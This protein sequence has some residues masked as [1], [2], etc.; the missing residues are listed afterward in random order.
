MAIFKRKFFSKCLFIM[1]K[2]RFFINFI[3]KIGLFLRIY[4]SL[5]YSRKQLQCFVISLILACFINSNLYAGTFLQKKNKLENIAQSINDTKNKIQ[6]NHAKKEKLVNQLKNI[7]INIGEVLKNIDR[8]T[9][10]IKVEQ[11]A[12]IKLHK[13]YLYLGLKLKRQIKILQSQAK[14]IYLLRQQPIIK[15]LLNNENPSTINRYAYYYNVIM[16]QRLQLIE[17]IKKTREDLVAVDTKFK[18]DVHSLDIINKKQKHEKEVLQKQQQERNLILKKTRANIENAKQQLNDL[19][20]NKK[21]L[22]SIIEKLPQNEIYAYDKNKNFA[23]LRGRLHWPVQKNKITQAFNQPLFGGRLYTNG[24]VI[25]GRTG[26]D[27][28]AVFKG[29]VVFANWVSGFGLLVIIQHDKKYL[30]LYG[31]NQ[32]LYVNVGDKVDSGAKIATVGNSGGFKTAGL[33]FEIRLYTKPLN[34]IFWLA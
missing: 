15:I 8:R 3:L 5:R 16:Q 29:Q 12:I 7:E 10:T 18:S 28:H 17:N 21:R 34:P 30:T 1:Y 22:A 4:G 25:G 6:I 20:A 33:Y 32:S 2:L 14:L 13:E 9:Q 23:D 11:A 19:F 24:I 27:V 26:E 31:H